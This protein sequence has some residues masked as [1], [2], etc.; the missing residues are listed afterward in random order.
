MSSATVARCGSSSDSSAPLWPCLAN[1]NFGPSSFEFGIDERGAIALEQFGRRQRAVELGQFRLVVEQLQ[2][3]RC[4]GH[5]QEDHALGL[6]GEMRRLGRQRVDAVAVRRSRDPVARAVGRAPSPPGRRRTAGGT[7]AGDLLRVGVAVRWSWQFMA[8]SL[9]RRATEGVSAD[10]WA[11]IEARPRPG[12]PCAGAVGAVD[13][14]RCSDRNRPVVRG[15]ARRC[16]SRETARPPWAIIGMEIE[17]DGI[18]IRE[19]VDLGH[20]ERLR[21]IDEDAI[22]APRRPVTQGHPLA[23]SEEID[24]DEIRIRAH[25]TMAVIQVPLPCVL[26][27]LVRGREH[28]DDRHEP[29]ARCL[30]D[31]EENLLDPIVGPAFRGPWTARRRRDPSRPGPACRVPFSISGTQDPRASGCSIIS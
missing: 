11:M 26:R 6:G 29:T 5:E 21:T 14:N 30:L 16:S 25:H 7:S 10:A 1:L 2:M 22:I 18:L 23:R 24:L 27:L 3:A 12:L 8:R 31:R 17:L 9:L 20:A 4:P 15:R 19:R 13:G 28:L